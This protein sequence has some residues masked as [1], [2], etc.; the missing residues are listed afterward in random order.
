MALL[1]MLPDHAYKLFNPAYKVAFDPD[2]FGA[3]V[4]VTFLVV[5]IRRGW[6]LAGTLALFGLLQLSQLLHFAYFGSLIAP[7]EVGLFFHEQ[8]E[9]WESL[10]GVAPYMLVPTAAVA[11]AYATIV[12]LWRKTHSQTL[13][14]LCPTLILLALLPIMPMKAYGTSKPQKFYANPKATSLKNTYY[15]V[16][17]FLGKDLPDRLN[18]KPAKEY[19][20]YQVIKRESPGP[21]NI[22][23]VMGESLGYSHMSLFGY[24]R[25]TTP[26]LESLKGDP[27]FVYKQA[28]AG[29]ISTKASLPL[30]FNVQREPDNVQHMFRYESNLIKMAREQGLAT[31]YIS[32][33]TSHLSTYSGTEY[34]DHYLTKENMEALYQREYDAALVT[35][36]KRIDLAKSNFIVLHQ[37]NSHSPYHYNYPPSFERY[38][39]ANLD[40]HQFTVNT[41]DNSVGFTDHVLYE[42]IRT[43]KEKSPVPTYVFFTADHGELIGEDGKYGHA[44]LEPGVAA[45]PFIFY[46]SRG[47]AEKVAQVRAMQHPSHYEIGRIIARVLGFEVVNPNEVDG[48]HYINGANLDGSAGYLAYRK[49]PDSKVLPLR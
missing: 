26:K 41:Y 25:S 24:E 2:E 10:A 48:I 43:L 38:P 17:F 32:N 27:G 44:M 49:G 16:S 36:L 21:I 15:A 33:Q 6:L 9:I 34:A 11:V 42:I 28:I 22:V 18:G 20:P 37:R 7:H 8:D 5:A 14:L 30:F 46:A 3:L 13:N 47:D 23:V 1:L 45:V 35:A 19:R 29:G 31:H 12:W 4:V 40:R 39:T